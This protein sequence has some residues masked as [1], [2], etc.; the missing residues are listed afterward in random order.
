MPDPILCPTYPHP[1]LAGW[2]PPSCSQLLCECSVSVSLAFLS[3]CPHPEALGPAQERGWGTEGLVLESSVPTGPFGLSHFCFLALLSP[4]LKNW[5]C[6]W[7]WFMC[8]CLPLPYIL[9]APPISWGPPTSI[10]RRLHVLLCVE[11]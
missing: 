8:V 6:S 3:S 5:M 10:N 11:S 9:P 4:Y 7:V 2:G 1:T